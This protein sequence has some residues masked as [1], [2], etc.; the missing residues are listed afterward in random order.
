MTR[1]QLIQKL[2][3]LHPHLKQK[4]LERVVELVF[5]NIS[6]ALH[7]GNRV[8]LRGFGAFSLRQRSDRQGRNPKTGETIQVEAKNT[9]YFRMGKELKQKLIK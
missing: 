7:Q 1:S 9:L 2:L 6:N 4:A 8:E 3:I 5:Q